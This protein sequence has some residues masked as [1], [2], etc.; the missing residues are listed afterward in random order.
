MSQV[1]SHITFPV[2]FASGKSDIFFAPKRAKEEKFAGLTKD[3]LCLTGKKK[4]SDT[5]L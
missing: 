3:L 4:F 2:S 1:L 5:L